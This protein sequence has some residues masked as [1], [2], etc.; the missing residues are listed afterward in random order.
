MRLTDEAWNGPA[1]RFGD[2]HIF[3][4]LHIL[5]RECRVGRVRLAEILEIGEGSVRKILSILR[6][7]GFIDV[8]QS[9]VSLS[10]DGEEFM[11]DIPM[12]VVDMPASGYVKGQCQ[13]AVLVRGVAESITNGMRQRDRGVVAGAKGTSVFVMRGGSVIMPKAWNIDERD[14][15]FAAVVRATGM[16]EGDALIIAG[17]PDQSAAAIAAISVGLELL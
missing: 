3:Y 12:V 1:C 16:A 11:R 10:E 5:D 8:K 7:W 13:Q 9:G 6:D 14:P 17:A 2:A 4:V 15:E